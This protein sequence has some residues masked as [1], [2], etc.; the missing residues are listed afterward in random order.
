VGDGSFDTACR[1]LYHKFK[2]NTSAI[3]ID[4][5]YPPGAAASGTVIIREGV[6]ESIFKQ[7]A[8]KMKQIDDEA[9]AGV[10]P[11]PSA[12]LAM[13]LGMTQRVDSSQNMAADGVR[14]SKLPLEPL[15]SSIWV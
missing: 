4:R 5:Q 1:D 12:D 6:E 8:R 3:I 10:A 14:G 2:N 11:P 9:A 13:L 7:I 15:L